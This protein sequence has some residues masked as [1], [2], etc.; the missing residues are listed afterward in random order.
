MACEEDER[1]Q[2]EIQEQPPHTLQGELTGGIYFA[3]EETWAQRGQAS[4][5]RS[6]R[7]SVEESEPASKGWK[8]RVCF[9]C[10]QLLKLMNKASTEVYQVVGSQ[11]SQAVG[12]EGEQSHGHPVPWT[13]GRSNAWES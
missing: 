11:E 7:C 8:S 10:A 2:L 9:I 6:H 13:A 3:G 1:K 5:R 12:G 4:R